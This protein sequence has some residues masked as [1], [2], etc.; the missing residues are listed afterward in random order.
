MKIHSRF[1]RFTLAFVRIVFLQGT[2]SFMAPKRVVAYR[3]TKQWKVMTECL[4]VSA[5]SQCLF[6]VAFIDLTARSTRFT[7]MDR[8]LSVQI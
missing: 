3:G 1:Q 2:S 4:Q 8:A 6:L 5:C 7:P